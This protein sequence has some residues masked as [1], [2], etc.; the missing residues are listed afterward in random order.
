MKKLFTLLTLLLTVCSGAWAE[1]VKVSRTLKSS[2][3]GYDAN[4]VTNITAS[5]S[6]NACKGSG[7]KTVKFGSTS[8]DV[9]DTYRDKKIDGST[10]L[11]TF[12]EDCY[13]G[14]QLDIA[15]GY[16]FTIT[17]IYVKVAVNANFTY[18][19]IVTDG[20]NAIYTSADKVIS[21]YDNDSKKKNLEATLS[22]LDPALV[23]SGKVY[24][25]VH[26]WYTTGSGT[27]YLVPLEISATGA[28]SDALST[29]TIATESSPVEGGT[30]TGGGTF[31][32]GQKVFLNA[33]KNSGF[34]FEKWQKDG[35]DFDGNTTAACTVLAS[36]NATYTAIF[37][38][39][40]T[41]Y[42]L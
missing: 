12:S 37:S 25:R 16:A 5:I 40:T 4:S 41:V 10:N 3:D 15:D 32:N 21:N 24:I 30:T 39:V 20:T 31:Y 1:D 22:G 19:I 18:R 29:Y 2:N 42:Q 14:L 7:S 6:D 36:A 33:S 35:A 11:T 17:K 8:Y 28:L 23:L 26:Y 34:A 13:A 38:A 9:T 27:K